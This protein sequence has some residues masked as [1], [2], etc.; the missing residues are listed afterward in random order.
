[1]REWERESYLALS[2]LLA[3]TSIR[4]TRRATVVDS[5][6]PRWLE[7]NGSRGMIAGITRDP[8][9]MQGTQRVNRVC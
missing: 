9:H 5:D 7:P 1:M 3:H 6:I 8:R 4:S 2:A